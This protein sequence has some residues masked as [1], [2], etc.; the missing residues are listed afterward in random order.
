M[1][2][3]VRVSNKERHLIFKMVPSGCDTDGILE[4]Y[5]QTPDD[6]ALQRGRGYLPKCSIN[7]TDIINFERFVSLEIEVTIEEDPRLK[8]F[9]V[10][11]PYSGTGVGVVKHCPDE[12][13]AGDFIYRAH[14]INPDWNDES[15]IFGPSNNSWE[16]FVLEFS[17][18]GKKEIGMIRGREGTPPPNFLRK[19]K[20]YYDSEDQWQEVKLFGVESSGFEHSTGTSLL[21]KINQKVNY[22]KIIYQSI[23]NIITLDYTYSK[24]DPIVMYKKYKTSAAFLLSLKKIIHEF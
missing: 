13:S 12:I 10:F 24:K 1:T 15:D 2:D 16:P 19:Y 22:Y 6:A 4:L 8:A 9:S 7:L 18:T 5:M 17:P 23:P 11:S 3:V 20:T 21:D 14:D